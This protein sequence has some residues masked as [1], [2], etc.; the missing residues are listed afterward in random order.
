M[1]FRR[2]SA[3]VGG[4]RAAKLKG[5]DRLFAWQPWLCLEGL[6]A[7]GN[8]GRL[9]RAQCVP[10]R[11]AMVQSSAAVLHRPQLFVTL[12]LLLSGCFNDFDLAS[13]TVRLSASMRLDLGCCVAGFSS[14]GDYCH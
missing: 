7:A 2:V 10:A 4:C 13:M 5:D 1:G 12:I 8:C 6:G 9:E 3:R 14:R 11:Q